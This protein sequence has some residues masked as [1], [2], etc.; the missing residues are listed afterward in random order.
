[1]FFIYNSFDGLQFID[2]GEKLINLTYKLL[3]ERNHIVIK[4]NNFP[5]ILF[6]NFIEIFNLF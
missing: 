5:L 1:M 6:I 4:M 3:I 2:S